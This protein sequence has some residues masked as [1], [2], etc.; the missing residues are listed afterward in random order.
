MIPA[1]PSL[2]LDV[3]IVGDEL[4][5]SLSGA[6]SGP[7]E[8]VAHRRLALDRVRELQQRMTAVLSRANRWGDIDQGSQQLL[9]QHGRLLLDEL[10]PGPVK[11]V[12]RERSGSDLT[13]VLDETLVFL[14]WEL[15]HTGRGFIGRE[16]SVGRIVRS[17][18]SV[19]G[20]ARPTPADRWRMLIL[21]DPRGDL[22]GSYYEGVTLR[23]E[24]DVRRRHLAI[25]MRTSE[26][27][28]ADVKELVREYDILH[29]A[30]HAELFSERPDDSGWLLRDG[31]LTP[32]ALLELAGGPSFPRLVFSNACRS[33]AVDGP[34]VPAHR[35]EAVFSLA[36]A[37]LLAGVRHYVGT[38]WDVPDEPAC[39]FALEFYKALVGGA[40]IGDAMRAAR[41]ALSARYGADTVLW[42]SHLLYG[43]PNTRLFRAHPRSQPRRR[44]GA[45]RNHATSPPPASRDTTPRAAVTRTRNSTGAPRPKAAS[46]AEHASVAGRSTGGS[47]LLGVAPLLAVVLAAAVFA[48]L[49][50][51]AGPLPSVEEGPRAAPRMRL[52]RVP[53]P[54]KLGVS[55]L[56]S[57]QLPAKI[58]AS[59][60]AVGTALEAWLQGARQEPARVSDRM[61][62]DQGTTFQI[63]YRTAD[64]AWSALW[65][66]TS[67]G[68]IRRLVVAPSGPSGRWSY[69]PAADRAYVLNDAGHHR[70]VLVSGETPADEAR[71]IDKLVEV[72]RRL[73]ELRRAPPTTSALGERPLDPGGAVAPEGLVLP[74]D[75]ALL[76][77]SISETLLEHGTVR[78]VDVYAR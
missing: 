64:D 44:I 55:P 13:L 1:A 51:D 20:G 3:A 67:D 46:Q 48:F 45:R 15:L 25:D 78:H 14:P 61:A 58:D 2:R 56:A 12:L 53:A 27:Q 37:F 28:V 73:R 30:G 70:F 43:D 62:L 40:T 18:Q 63:R 31:V 26:V 33:G 16:Y 57:S 35:S 75:E 74:P 29:Y 8:T 69:L 19:V 5:A 24:L 76:L 66:V 39:H 49:S 71:L 68:D 22:M 23:D 54:G 34:L 77:R 38:L 42:A 6:G 21:C 72:Q 11:D 47:G 10:L 36:N 41:E 50:I 4:R 60:S 59:G 7:V 52:D 65:H 17:R 32:S 9:R